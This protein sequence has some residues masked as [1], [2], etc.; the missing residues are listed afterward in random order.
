MF[1]IEREEEGA[2]L[3]VESEEGIAFHVESEDGV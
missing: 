1:F 2:S 3:H